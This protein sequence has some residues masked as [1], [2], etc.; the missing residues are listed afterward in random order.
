MD[1][2]PDG[3]FQEGVESFKVSDGILDLV[4][5]D[6]GINHERDVGNAETDDLNGVLGLEGIPDQDEF[7]D[8]TEQEQTEEGGNRLEFGVDSVDVGSGPPLGRIDI[9][10]AALE[11]AES[12][13]EVLG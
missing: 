8:E 12:V 4:D 5:L 13:T 3:G 9:S 1:I 11:T 10:K 6:G 7:V 2:T